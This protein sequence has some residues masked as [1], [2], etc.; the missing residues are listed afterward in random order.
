MGEAVLRSR[1]C[2]IR[3]TQAKVTDMVIASIRQGR[4]LFRGGIFCVEGETKVTYSVGMVMGG[5]DGREREELVI[6]DIC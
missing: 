2:L 1:V 6:L 3:R 5:Y 4:D